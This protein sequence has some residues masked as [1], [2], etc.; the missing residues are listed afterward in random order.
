MIYI[1]GLFGLVFVIQFKVEEYIVMIYLQ[2]AG[3]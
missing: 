1:S 3:Y 2:L